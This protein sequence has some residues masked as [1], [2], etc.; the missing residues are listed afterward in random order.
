MSL[1][2]EGQDNSAVQ[3]KELLT[4]DHLFVYTVL[5]RIEKSVSDI[6]RRVEIYRS[7]KGITSPISNL[8]EIERPLYGL[9]LKEILDNGVIVFVQLEPT[10]VKRRYYF[11]E[12]TNTARLYCEEYEEGVSVFVV[13]ANDKFNTDY[14]LGIIGD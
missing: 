6:Q 8:E 11:A 3:V 4:E 1:I 9:K 13:S 12:L 10:Y 7:S 14:F 5:S 2:F